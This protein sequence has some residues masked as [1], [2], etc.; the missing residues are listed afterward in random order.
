MDQA[1]K[2]IRLSGRVQGVGF[3]HFTRVNA[4]ELG[5]LGWVRNLPDGDV[6]AVL[7]GDRSSVDTLIERLKEGPRMARVDN[8]SVDKEAEALSESFREFSVRH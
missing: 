4:K 3:R 6:E 2:H 5:V 7:Q 1:K 8:L